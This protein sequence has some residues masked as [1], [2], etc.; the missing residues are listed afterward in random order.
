M[1]GSVEDYD[2]DPKDDSSD[3]K[4]DDDVWRSLRPQVHAEQSKVVENKAIYDRVTGGTDDDEDDDNKRKKS[5]RRMYDSGYATDL[6]Q[7]QVKK[8]DE[9]ISELRK[10]KNN[11]ESDFCDKII[12]L[13]NDDNRKNNFL[14]NEEFH[15]LVAEYLLPT[16]SYSGIGVQFEEKDPNYPKKSE[17]RIHKVFDNS[18][19]SMIGLEEGDVIVLDEKYRM[20]IFEL[21]T[22]LRKGNLEPVKEIVRGGKAIL[23]QQDFININAKFDHIINVTTVIDCEGSKGNFD[24]KME[25][26][27]SKQQKDAIVEIKKIVENKKPSLNL[28][29][30]LS[31][32]LSTKQGNDAKLLEENI[33]EWAKT[34]SKNPN[35]E[36]YSKEKSK[37]LPFLEIDTVAY[38]TE[39]M[40]DLSNHKLD[41]KDIIDD[42]ENFFKKSHEIA[43]PSSKIINST[44]DRNKR[45]R[46]VADK[47]YY[48]VFCEEK[49]GD[50]WELLYWDADGVCDPDNPSCILD[51]N[52]KEKVT[53]DKR[54]LNTENNK[55]FIVHNGT[56][57][58]GAA[59]LCHRFLSGGD[60]NGLKRTNHIEYIKNFVR[61]NS[62]HQ[63]PTPD[64]QTPKAQALCLKKN[65][66]QYR[67]Y[68]RTRH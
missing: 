45:V 9:Q 16:N 51:D 39:F 54:L 23:D 12:E 18:F 27:F 44:S 32:Y 30:S 1:A 40:M 11:D 33:K 34:N 47:T 63:N 67:D 19:A 7:M 50:E 14:K 28:F 48:S 4:S 2:H 35:V 61:K 52:Y 3:C 64:P 42:A 29:D 56:C 49:V 20:N 68:T 21:V 10:L 26:E 6:D 58:V 43:L 66:H 31:N 24:I 57:G 22:H 38:L 59:A 8:T 37:N 41:A 65:A 53:K 62:T 5:M 17:L 25:S 46:I 15:K 13:L 60:V 55:G 36:S